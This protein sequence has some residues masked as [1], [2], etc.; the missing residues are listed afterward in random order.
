MRRLQPPQTDLLLSDGTPSLFGEE[1]SHC[2]GMS[3]SPAIP[4][5]RT[6]ITPLVQA[7]VPQCNP[8]VAAFHQV[9][10]FNAEP[11]LGWHP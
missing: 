2:M 3:G 6:S 10:E 7:I 5:L 1:S 11:V 9:F 4:P 8:P